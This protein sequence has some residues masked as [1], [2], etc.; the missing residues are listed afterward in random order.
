MAFAVDTPVKE[1]SAKVEDIAH[2]P[3]YLGKP[4]LARL[5]CS[6]P[7]SDPTLDIGF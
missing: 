1:G 5:V 2:A 3:S 7:R 4:D 6:S